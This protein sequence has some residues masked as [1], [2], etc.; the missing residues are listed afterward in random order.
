MASE[1]HDPDAFAEKLRHWRENGGLNFTFGGR[2]GYGSRSEFH[3]QPSVAQRER[4]HVAELK[5]AGVEFE[6]PSR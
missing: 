3:D 4:R 5:A 6:R 2:H 1:S